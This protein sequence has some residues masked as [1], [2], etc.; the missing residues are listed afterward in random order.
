MRHDKKEELLSLFIISLVLIA[1]SVLVY[2]IRTP[3]ITGNI[4]LGPSLTIGIISL[5]I[6]ISITVIIGAII[7]IHKLEK[8]LKEHKKT[9]AQNKTVL[10]EHPNIELVNYVME[11]RRQGFTDRHI[12]K[13][14]K[15]EGWN[16]KEVKRYL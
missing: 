5:L 16:A 4:A 12:L 7:T 9:L 15:Q 13:K 6:L 10:F 11:A 8:E 3:S 14:L 1:V 2:M